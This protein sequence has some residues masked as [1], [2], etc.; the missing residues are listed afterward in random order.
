[1]IGAGVYTTSG[2]TLASLGSPW[3]VI[4]AWA[5]GGVVAI[6]GAISYGALASRFTESGGEYLFLGRTLHPL[7]GLMAGWVSL[8]A[9][10]TSPIAV[11][12]L[13]C[14][15]YLLRVLGI[16]GTGWLP[17]GGVAIALIAAAAVLHTASVRPSARFQDGV[18]GLKLAMIVGFIVVAMVSLRGRWQGW[19]AWPAAGDIPP[20][21]F[22]T[23]L[24]Y[25]SFSYAGF[26][27]AIY[28]AGEVRDAARNV[29][30][31]LVAGTV[32]VTVL[33]VVLNSIFVLAPPASSIRG[34]EQIAAI[35]AET[36]GGRGF[37]IFVG[38]VIVVSLM[39]SVSAMI[40]SGPRV[41]AK[42]AD[43]GYLPSWFS[44]ESQPPKVAIWFQA[45][46]AVAVVC[47]ASLQSLLSYLGFT[48]SVSSALTVGMI[49]VLRRRGE[50]VRT[51]WYPLPP[52]LFVVATLA[53]A[54]IA[55]ANEWRQAAAAAITLGLG[56]ALYPFI[57]K[58]RSS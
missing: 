33:Y 49:F 3:L 51:V 52:L 21:G 22:A 55:A 18:V 53:T 47:V 31:A 36:I 2:Y 41:Y 38:A 6:S 40:M 19:T 45:A 10:F 35:A 15:A 4:A 13:A 9:G 12:A 54:A 23:S 29:P 11:A 32:A 5:I 43:D 50:P 34:E 28:F 25:I 44:F 8:L 20:L 1:M 27:A 58:R 39:T 42:M 7:A 26:N 46:A 24:L 30:R 57:R 14:E 48:L 16:E 56:A 37:S 17:A